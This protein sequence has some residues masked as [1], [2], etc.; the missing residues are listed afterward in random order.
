MEEEEQGPEQGAAPSGAPALP[1]EHP[2]L[3]SAAPA[4]AASEEPLGPEAGARMHVRTSDLT[5]ARVHD[6]PSRISPDEMTSGGQAFVQ[7]TMFVHNV[8]VLWA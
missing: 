4:D 2:E 1:E 8:N 7:V 3:E 5:V 6:S